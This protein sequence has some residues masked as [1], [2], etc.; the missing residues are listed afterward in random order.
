LNGITLEEFT[1]RI[2]GAVNGVPGL[3]GVWVIA[4][5]SD[6]RR[7][8]HCYLELVQKHP[9]TGDPVAR[10]RATVWRG[11]LARIDAKFTGATGQR[12]ESGMKVM[13][14][15]T[16]SFHPA[17]G[18]SANI[19]DI[20]PSY[21]LGDLMRRRLEIINRLKAEGV[22]D[23][24]RQLEW[25]DVPLRIAVISARGAA[26]YGDFIHQLYTSP[27]KL[28][29]RVALFP[30][31]MQGAS[32][33]DSIICALE[34]IAAE[35]EMWDCVVIIRGGGATS[36]LAAFDNYDLAANIAQFP[37][38][39]IIGIGHERDVTV[40]DAVANMR[41]KTPTAAAE[42]LI[43]RGEEALATLHDLGTEIYRLAS[44]LLAGSKEQLARLSAILP[45]LPA[46]AMDNARKRVD[47][48]NVAL[49]DVAMARLRPEASRLDVMA[50]RI[51]SSSATVIERQRAMLDRM[52]GLVQ[53]LSPQATLS[54]GYSITRVNGHA[55]TDA[56][57][58]A[59]GDI[60]ETTLAS[61]TIESKVS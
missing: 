24:N 15:V 56:S 37:L 20:D 50:E 1:A 13:V 5:T 4:E 28:A 32:A 29:F 10:L 31:L 19:T 7:N 61:G 23:L 39:V 57:A 34:Q 18:L 43:A 6:V 40:L 54:R 52:D 47:R 60:I 42:W 59:P 51:A 33:P 16:A 27:S 45:Q 2:A 9:V 44:D 8:G 58:L 14:C 48:L 35:E 26:G 25:P 21:T 22:I 3:A 53:V 17:Y 30:A 46:I 55:V 12:L 49:S 41:V 38:P 11:T 36:D